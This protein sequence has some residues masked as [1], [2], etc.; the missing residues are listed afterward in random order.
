MAKDTVLI[1]ETKLLVN[2]APGLLEHQLITP[3]QLI[4]SRSTPIQQKL[5]LKSYISSEIYPLF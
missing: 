1:G 4:G 5:L 2:G 3:T